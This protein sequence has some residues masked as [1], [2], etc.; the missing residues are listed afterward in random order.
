[1][2]MVPE[3]I[4]RIFANPLAPPKENFATSPSGRGDETEFSH[5]VISEVEDSRLSASLTGRIGAFAL[6]YW[7][8]EWRRTALAKAPPERKLDRK[9]THIPNGKLLHIIIN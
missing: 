6:N 4:R 7:I 9:K 1:M 5:A 2:D 8:L 3:A